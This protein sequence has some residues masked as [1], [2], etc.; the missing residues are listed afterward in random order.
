[1]TE[2]QFAERWQ[3]IGREEA[4]ELSRREAAERARLEARLER[5]G[6]KVRELYSRPKAL[7]IYEALSPDEHG[8]SLEQQTL[9]KLTGMERTILGDYAHFGHFLVYVDS[10]HIKPTLQ[11]PLFFERLTLT[12]FLRLLSQTETGAGV[13]SRSDRKVRMAD[14]ER[15]FREMIDKVNAGAGQPVTKEQVYP[16][17]EALVGRKKPTPITS[18]IQELEQRHPDQAVTERGVSMLIVNFKKRPDYYVEEV[19]TVAGRAVRV[20]KV[21]RVS[22]G[23][24]IVAVGEAIPLL[25]EILELASRSTARTSLTQI[26]SNASKVLKALKALGR[27]AKTQ[28]E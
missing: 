10:D 9:A 14:Y 1:M 12:H 13:G 27:W 26:S 25:D 24:A 8:R 21:S 22:A 16:L 19:D 2:Q 11:T 7:L 3:V 5:A 6:D 28:E 18:I 4:E 23:E 20:H 15:R 17:L